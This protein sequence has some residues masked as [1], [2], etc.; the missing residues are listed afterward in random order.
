M[1]EILSLPK[2]LDGWAWRYRFANHVFRRHRHEELEL[3]LVTSGSAS[4]LVGDRR[5]D[6]R[7][8]TLVWLFP[9][10]EHVLLEQSPNYQMWIAVFRPPLLRRAATSPQTL[11]LRQ[12]SPAGTFCRRLDDQTSARLVGL[13]SDLH[14][15]ATDPQRFNAGLAYALLTAWSSFQGANE[16]ALGSALHPAVE[17]AAALIR[18]HD[19]SDPTLSL[20]DLAER[21]GLSPSRLSR[22]FKRQTGV[23]LVRYRQQINLQRFLTLYGAGQRMN[24][25]SAALRAGFG[26][27][28]QFHRVFKQVIGCSPNEYRRRNDAGDSRRMSSA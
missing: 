12:P 28:P 26:S 24:M 17:R 13:L 10:Q 20:D 7:R 2:G 5:Y 15:A 11:A 14:D 27:Y 21:S 6:L 9:A 1:R 18:E 23:S 25:M 3:N 16:L 22:L 4:Y 8:G 19:G